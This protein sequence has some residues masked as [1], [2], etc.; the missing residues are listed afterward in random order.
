M[1]TSLT[2]KIVIAVS[3]LIVAMLILP[4][5][6]VKLAPA[7]FGMALCLILF[8]AVEPFVVMSLG[9][10]AGTEIRKLWWIPVVSAAVFPLFFGVAVGELVV[11]LFVY[12]AI[13]LCMGALAMLG[14]Y[15]V[16]KRGK[17]KKQ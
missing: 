9:V 6:V 14:T 1:R 12:S 5:L 7:D 13:Y 8:F 11:E 3:T 17:K 16:V 4:I 15:Y 2:R 10:M